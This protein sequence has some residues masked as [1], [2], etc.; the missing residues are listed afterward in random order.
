MKKA[1]NLPCASRHKKIPT[2]MEFKRKQVIFS[3]IDTVE[4][5]HIFEDAIMGHR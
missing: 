3:N 4:T 1:D 2:G 5:M